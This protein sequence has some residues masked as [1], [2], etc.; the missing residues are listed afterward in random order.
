MQGINAT[1]LLNVLSALPLHGGERNVAGVLKYCAYR[2]SRVNVT[3]G[4]SGDDCSLV[5]LRSK[6]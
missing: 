2:F 4:G 5:Y 3:G 6:R 1:K